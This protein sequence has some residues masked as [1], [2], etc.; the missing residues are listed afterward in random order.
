MQGGK[1]GGSGSTERID[2]P[3]ARCCMDLDRHLEGTLCLLSI[4][5]LSSHQLGDVRPDVGAPEELALRRVLLIEASIAPLLTQQRYVEA[6][7]LLDV[8]TVEEVSA[9]L[10]GE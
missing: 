5:D 6:P 2:H 4:V 3:L 10:A 7:G 1:C 8:R 9:L